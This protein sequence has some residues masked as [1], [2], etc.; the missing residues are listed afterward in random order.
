M[1]NLSTYLVVALV[2]DL[3]F[4]V[5]I[6][7]VVDKSGGRLLMID[8]PE[9]LTG[10]HEPDEAIRVPSHST[11]PEPDER[12]FIAL[13]VAENPVLLIVDLNNVAVPWEAWIRAVKRDPQTRRI[14]V[15]AFGSHVNQEQL[16]LAREAGADQV[17]A[18]S[19][20]VQVLPGLVARSRP[21]ATGTG[22]DPG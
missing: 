19:R 8:R 21:D 14:P 4:A 15:V 9:T 6:Q 22:L 12:A 10:K 11:H 5:R 17:L 2:A 20:F 18:K 16:R 3:Y 1:A 7:S 13:L